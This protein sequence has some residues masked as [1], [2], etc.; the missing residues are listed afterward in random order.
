MKKRGKPI[1]AIGQYR[2][3]GVPLPALVN[4]DGT[5]RM[6][7]R[8]FFAVSHHHA[9]R[10]MREI[11]QFVRSTEIVRDERIVLEQRKTYKEAREYCRMLNDLR[12]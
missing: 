2:Y 3:V 1:D 8:T 7:R 12:S 6:V 11:V 9:L 4:N 5:P 10:Y